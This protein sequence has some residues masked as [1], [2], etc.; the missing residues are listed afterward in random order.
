[1]EVLHWS[2]GTTDRAYSV[3]DLETYE[4]EA[5][6]DRIGKGKLHSMEK[7]LRNSSFPIAS[8]LPATFAHHRAPPTLSIN[9]PP[10]PRVKSKA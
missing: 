7:E 10:Q 4:Q 3:L 2:L 9:R 6:S 5:V 1:M 8:Y